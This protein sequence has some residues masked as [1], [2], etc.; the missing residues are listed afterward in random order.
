[1]RAFA[2]DQRERTLETRRHLLDL[3]KVEAGK[4]DVRAADVGLAGVR[5]YVERTFRPLAEEK[6]L[7]LAV[8]IAGAEV[9]PTIFTDEQRL[10]QVLKNLLSNAVKFT[11]DGA[12]TMR[13]ERAPKDVQLASSTLTRADTVLAF[14][15]IDTGIGIAEEKLRLIFEAFQQADGTTSRKYG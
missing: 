15:V 7:E 2:H 3:S 8:E 6:G 12:V 9:A 11:D 13:I 1:M 5:D 4:M 10:Q 14:S